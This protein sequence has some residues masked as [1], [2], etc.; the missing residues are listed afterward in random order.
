MNP[1]LTVNL[2]LR[3]GD[4][5]C[6]FGT[7]QD[8]LVTFNPDVVNPLLAGQTNPVTGQPYLGAFELV[9]S[10]GQPER[11]LRKESSLQFAPRVGV[12][13][14]I[15]DNTVLRGGGGTFYLPSTVTIPGRADGQPRASSARTTSR[16]AS[17]TTA[18][19]SP[20]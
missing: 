20:T 8:R 1:K 15:T 12:A 6:V 2:G 7:K 9:A 14:R 17:T 13:Y 16:P 10:D 19:S 18:R 5:G 3:V 11:T 4:A